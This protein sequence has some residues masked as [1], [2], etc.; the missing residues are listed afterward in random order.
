MP[1]VIRPASRPSSH[2]A[3]VLAE[4]ARSM[5]QQPTTSEQLL[6]EA[7]RGGKLGVAFKRQVV[8]LGK[9]IADLCAPSI[10]LVV[11]VDG[12]YHE[13]TVRHDEKRDRALARAGYRVLR[14]EAELVMRD[15][16]GAVERVR[17]AVG[18]T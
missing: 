7:L 13:R 2:R 10:G 8:L 1:N 17:E 12:G 18:D 14:I 5:R 11:E 15:V 16:A 3:L 6:F 9:Y 4:R